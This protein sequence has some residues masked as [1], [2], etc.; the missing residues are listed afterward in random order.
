MNRESKQSRFRPTKTLASGST[1]TSIR[2]WSPNEGRELAE[3]LTAPSQGEDT[4]PTLWLAATP[5]GYYDCAE[6]ADY[7]VKWR[8][9]KKLL[10]FYHFEESY[11]Q[12]TILQQA[13]AGQKVK[14]RPLLLTRVP[15]AIRIIRPFQS[16]TLTG[17]SVRVLAEAAD[18]G[19]INNFKMYVNGVLVPDSVAKPIIVDGK[20]IIVDGKP[21]IVD[22]KPIIVDGKPIIVEGKPIIVGGKPIIVGGK[23]IV[24]EGKPLMAEGGDVENVGAEYAV[25]KFFVMDIPLP[26]TD[27]NVTLR[28]VVTDSEQNKSDAAVVFKSVTTAP[29]QGDLYVLCVGVSDYRNPLYNIPFAAGDARAMLGVLQAQKRQSLRQRLHQDSH[30]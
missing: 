3:L 4:P 16:A 8:F 26:A 18:D 1:D 22:G 23:P 17:K 29:V 14:A 30:R 20:P 19:E 7:L 5:E 24:V 15:P 13:L 28:L 12:P 27:E 25:H 11:R 2:I 10:P 9:Q 6:G 21:I